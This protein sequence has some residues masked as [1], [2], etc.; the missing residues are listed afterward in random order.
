HFE[1]SQ[2]DS[3]SLVFAA[4]TLGEH[5]ARFALSGWEINKDSFKIAI[6]NQIYNTA[7]GDESIA[8]PYSAYS[9][10]KVKIGMQRNAQWTLFWKIFLGMYV[11]FL[12]A[13]ACFFIDIRSIEARFGLNVGA[14]F[15]AVGNKYVIDSSLPDSTSP[16]LVDTLHGLTLIFI[17]AVILSTINV[18]KLVSK[19]RIDKAIRFDKNIALILLLAYIVCNIYFIV[20]ANIG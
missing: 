13:F 19:E 20:Q 8:K 15:A 9:A 3:T 5:F 18:L 17:F 2:F 1:N 7:F 11:A 12:I 16:T 10:F 6:K 4:D 14:L